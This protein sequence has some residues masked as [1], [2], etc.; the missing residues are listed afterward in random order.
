MLTRWIKI[1]TRVQWWRN[2]LR[3]VGKCSSVQQYTSPPVLMLQ[4]SCAN[5]GTGLQT[6]WSVPS[7]TLFVVDRIPVDVMDVGGDPDAA[8]SKWQ[9]QT[10]KRV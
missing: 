7:D 6:P 1:T 8:N 9:W 2:V 10:H 3:Q 4:V 5:R